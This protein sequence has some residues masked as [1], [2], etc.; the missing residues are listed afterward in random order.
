ML[1]LFPWPPR[2]QLPRNSQWKLGID[3]NVR[4]KLNRGNEAADLAKTGTQ[5]YWVGVEWGYTTMAASKDGAQPSIHR[6]LSWC[7]L[8]HG[9]VR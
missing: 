5:T 9:F 8:R 2:A 4:C 7:R 6:R 1:V 3:G